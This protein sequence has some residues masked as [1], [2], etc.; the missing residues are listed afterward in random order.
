MTAAL[1]ASDLDRTLIYSR[2]FFPAVPGAELC[3]EVH[4]GRPISYMTEAAMA[5]LADLAARYPVVPATTRTIAQY[6]RVRLPGPPPR[7]AVTSNG[8]RILVDGAPDRG[9]SEQ[10]AEAIRV[11]G[12][13]IDEVVEALAPTLPQPWVRNFKVAEGLFCY[14][15]VRQELLPGDFVAG[16]TDWCAPRGW[17][18]SRQG[19]KIYAV[20]SVLCKSRAVAEVRRRLVAAGELA[21]DAVLLAAGD[22]ALDAELLAGADAAIRPA[23]GELEELAWHRDSVTVTSR[24]GA[25]AAEEI[26]AWLTD[27]AQTARSWGG[28]PR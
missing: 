16:W 21:P 14:L 28:R 4:D 7:H 22:G 11:G 5:A 18:V 2:K 12:V 23:H 26:L 25:A 8:G 20:P 15:V 24:A 9:W 27:R 3:V 13:G 6:R 10:T 1:I 19:R 17:R